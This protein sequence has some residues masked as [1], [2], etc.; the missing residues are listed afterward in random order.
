MLKQL[1]LMTTIVS[2]IALADDNK[3]LTGTVKIDGSST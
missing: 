2:G 1:I 3:R